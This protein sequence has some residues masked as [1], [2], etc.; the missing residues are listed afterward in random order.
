[1]S[2]DQPKLPQR[3]TRLPGASSPTSRPQPSAAPQAQA[4]KPG[5]QRKLLGPKFG[6]IL[7]VV[8]LVVA[9]GAVGIYSYLFTPASPHM[10]R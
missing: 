7:G 2:D 8:M 9:G 3:R 5:K 4:A 6:L 10:A 1:M